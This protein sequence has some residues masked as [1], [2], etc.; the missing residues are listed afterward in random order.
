MT[1]YVVLNLFFMLVAG[2]ACAAGDS[3][4][5]RLFYLILLFAICSSSL[6]DLDGL[7]GRQALLGI[8]SLVYFVM[9]GVTDLVALGVGLS[10]EHSTSL[11]SAT[12]TV[13]LVGGGVLV[14]A[15]RTAASLS[16]MAARPE[17][18]RDWSKLSLLS[19]GILMWTI[20]TYAT[21][22]WNVYIVTDT[23]NE[24]IRKGL[25][26][27]S[28]Y[29]ISGY[30]LAQ[31]MQ[32]LGILLIAYTWRK[33]RPPFIWVFVALIVIVQVVIGFIADIKGLAMLG[34]ILMILTYVLVD[35][36]I[37]KRWLVGAV[38][39]VLFIFPIFQAYRTAIHGDRGVARTAVVANFA[40]IVSLTLSASD[41]VNSGHQR[42]QTFLE[43]S[44]LL[45]SV[46]TIVDGTAHGV[47]YQD[48][49][50]LTPLFATFVPKIV[51]SDK[52]DIPAGQILNKA[53]HISESDDVFISPSHL[54]ELYWNFGWSGV[55]VGMTLIGGILGVVGARFNLAQGASVTRLMVTVVTIK[56][57][58]TG[59]ESGIAPQYVV[60]LRS[61]AG[62]GVLHLIFARLP[63]A[64][65]R[66]SIHPVQPVRALAEG[67]TSS[68]VF[69]NL[70]C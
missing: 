27:R 63:V 32:P 60:W 6:I 25:Q 65:R 36:R 68:N 28:N 53:F 18:C 43:R 58:V 13:V 10:T 44:S 14:L 70:L 12:E 1:A 29:V 21:Y 54:G 24:A 67:T 61:L 3:P 30:I 2:V 57:L 26:S 4:N 47:P 11:L 40:H 56:Q 69:P 51:W 37:P 20:G 34:G 33:F 9:F 8:F 39:Y 38:A 50:T 15:Y 55:I 45:E 22:Q 62:I 31:M 46:Q 23:T 7:N 48:G 35:G 42:A 59:F 5:P 66:S 64:V 19:V 16:G 49:H 41:R 52:P 17:R